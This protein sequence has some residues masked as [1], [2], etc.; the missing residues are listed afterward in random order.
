MV[1]KVDFPKISA[2]LSLS[3]L[4]T[5]NAGCILDRQNAAVPVASQPAA[6]APRVQLRFASRPT[7]SLVSHQLTPRVVVVDARVPE[8]KRYYPGE[9]ES[10]RNADAI[11]ILPLES[12]QPAFDKALKEKVIS[13]LTD[14]VDY[15][16]IEIRLKSFHVALDE[17]S[18]EQ[19]DEQASAASEESEATTSAATSLQRLAAPVRSALAAMA[20]RMP[21]SATLKDSTSQSTLPDLLVRSKR[22][23]WN[24]VLHVDVV[25]IDRNGEQRTLPVETAVHQPDD[26]SLDTNRQVQNIVTLALDE[27]TKQLAQTDREVAQTEPAVD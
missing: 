14:A 27:F 18:M 25:A 4:L 26:R 21:G 20:E 9:T 13:G 16:L 7:L 23:G 19:P 3:F 12:F 11:A 8:E 17:R 6:E 2:T 1:R 24:C 10:T 22:A 15:E 5:I